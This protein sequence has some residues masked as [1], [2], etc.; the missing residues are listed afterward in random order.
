M[1]TT[2]PISLSELRQHVTALQNAIRTTEQSARALLALEEIGEFDLILPFAHREQLRRAVAVIGKQ[3]GK[4]APQIERMCDAV[5]IRDGAG[6]GHR[7]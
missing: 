5:E 4:L 1:T 7:R 2:K 6:A 3:V